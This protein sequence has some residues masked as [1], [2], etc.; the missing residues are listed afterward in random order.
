MKFKAAAFD[1]DGTL[2]HLGVVAP[3]TLDALYRLKESGRKLVLVT[4]RQLDDIKRAF[5]EH[6][7]FDR[8]VAEN[9]ALLYS[10]HTE[11]QTILADPA[12]RLFV[13]ELAERGV[14]PLSVGRCIIATYTTFTQMISEVIRELSLEYWIIHNKEHAMAL[15]VG[16]DKAY[17]LHA[18]LKELHLDCESAVAF[19]D[20]ENDESMFAASGFGVAVQ[21]AV[22]GLKVLALYV[23]AGDHGTGVIESIDLLLQDEFV[24]LR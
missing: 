14:Q 5:P 15:P 18:A 22:A 3:P 9:G 8:I 12:D 1:Y 4:G 21:N 10:P 17:G 13:S 2:A 24:K 23:S 19:G 20:G 6:I 16:V 7:H 11:V